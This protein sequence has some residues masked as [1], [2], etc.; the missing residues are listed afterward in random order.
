MTLRWWKS[1]LVLLLSIFDNIR[2]LFERMDS[3]IISNRTGK[4][5]F[6]RSV[7][8]EKWTDGHA[9]KIEEEEKEK[10]W[11]YREIF[12]W[13]KEKL[14]CQDKVMRC[15]EVDLIL[16]KGKIRRRKFL[17]RDSLTIDDR[18]NWNKRYNIFNWL[19]FLSCQ[20]RRKKREK[21]ELIVRE[22][23]SRLRMFNNQIKE[24]QVVD[25][26]W[27]PFIETFQGRMTK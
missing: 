3:M 23:L 12:S 16:K 8:N 18:M 10:P 24:L 2:N 17:W 14:V 9:V 22:Y 21:R 4:E 11:S 7:S 25:D 5:N 15:I 20:W 26:M 19:F 6:I 1:V 13:K 27:L